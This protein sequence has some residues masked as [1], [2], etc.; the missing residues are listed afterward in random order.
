MKRETDNKKILAEIQKRHKGEKRILMD[1]QNW[2][3]DKY[4]IPRT[5]E[6]RQI[7][8]DF[9]GRDLVD[10]IVDYETGDLPAED[11]LKLFADLIKTGQ[12]W[13]LQGHYGRTAQGLIDSGYIAKSGEILKH[14]GE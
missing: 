3:E 5:K 10:M 11:T 8:D 7:I 4:S 12:C 13:T 6:L 2:I 9:S 14:L 1:Y